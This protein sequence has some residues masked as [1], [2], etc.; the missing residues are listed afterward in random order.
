MARAYLVNVCRRYTH[1]CGRLYDVRHRSHTVVRQVEEKDLEVK[2]F[3]IRDIATFMPVMCVRLASTTEEE[4]YLLA[5][6]GYGT[7]YMTQR[8]Y[9]QMINLS[10]GSGHS[11]CDPHEWPGGAST[12]PTAHKYIIENWDVLASGDVVDVEHILDPTKEPKL[13]ERLTSPI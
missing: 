13:S 8:Q 6:A 7:D 4:R 9:V 12:L 5:R 11:T 10:G 1:G 3:E 2:L